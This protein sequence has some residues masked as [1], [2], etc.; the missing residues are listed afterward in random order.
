MPYEWSDKSPAALKF[1]TDVTGFFFTGAVA[2]TVKYRALM[3]Q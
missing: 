2:C 1:T 3:N